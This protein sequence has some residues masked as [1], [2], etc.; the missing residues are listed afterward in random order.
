MFN[1]WAITNFYRNR[2]NLQMT[3][4][5]GNSSSISLNIPEPLNRMSHYWTLLFLVISKVHKLGFHMQWHACRFRKSTLGPGWG[6]GGFLSVE[7]V[8]PPW[9]RVWTLNIM[10]THLVFV[11]GFDCGGFDRL[12]GGGFDRLAGGVRSNQSNPPG[13][14]PVKQR[15]VIFMTKLNLS[16]PDWSELFECVVI[17]LSYCNRYRPFFN[18]TNN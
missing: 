4:F 9:L 12:R 15:D 3:A 8:E 13:Y 2:Q 10:K 1:K 11:E 6:G 14:G 17:D 18:K 7:P 16:S 5:S